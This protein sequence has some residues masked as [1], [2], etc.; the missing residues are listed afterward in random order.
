M[1]DKVL[2]AYGSKYG[3][4]SEIAEKIGQVL[5]EKGLEADV[6]EADKVGGLT[7]Y[8]AVVVGSAVYYGRWRKPAV[9]FLEKNEEALAALPVWI[10]SSGPSGEGDPV[11]LAKG[12]RS[13]KALQPAIDHIKPRDIKLFS[14]MVDIEKLGSLEKFAIKKVEAPS[15]DFRDWDDIGAWTAGIADALK[16]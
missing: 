6:V 7:G 3:A 8:A 9:K 1:G 5:A 12:W 11:E 13:P 4:T 14:G 15:G 2:V 16:Q 10:F